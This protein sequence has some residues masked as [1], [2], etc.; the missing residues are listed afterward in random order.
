[1]I[2]TALDD[3]PLQPVQDCDTAKAVWDQL[4]H[5]Y[6]AK[7]MTH[8]LRALANLLKTKYKTNTDLTDHAAHLE[9]QLACQV[10]I[11]YTFKKLLK[12]DFLHPSVLSH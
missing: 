10:E 2:I 3:N 5:R 1:M 8:R 4:Q 9:S 7:T 11:G 12:A 6:A